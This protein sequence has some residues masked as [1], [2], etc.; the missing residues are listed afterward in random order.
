M[1]PK[2]GMAEGLWNITNP[3]NA[4]NGTKI[5]E[6]KFNQ[7]GFISP[8]SW[9]NWVFW[10]GCFQSKLA[11]TFWQSSDPPEVL[12]STLKSQDSCCTMF[13]AKD[14]ILFRKTT[15]L[16]ETINSNMNL[17]KCLFMI[18]CFLCN[19]DFFP[20]FLPFFFVVK[21]CIRERRWSHPRCKKPSARVSNYPAW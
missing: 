14:V 6:P 20:P 21:L 18:I 17:D 8:K 7:L 11:A 10:G 13:L 4:Q 16:S 1:K 2:Q 3:C 19:I 9:V 5:L 15:F 12:R